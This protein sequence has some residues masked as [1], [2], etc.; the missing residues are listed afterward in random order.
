MADVRTSIAG[1]ASLAREAEITKVQDLLDRERAC[2]LVG[3][4]GSGKSALA[5]QIAEGNYDRRVWFA[6]TMLDHDT[7]RAFERAIDITHPFR[8]ILAASAQTCLIVFDSI[9]RYSARAHRLACRFMQTVLAEGSGINAHILVTGQFEPATRIL[10][11]F[12]EAGLPPA[13]HTAMPLALPSA[14]AIQDLVAPIAELQWASLRPELR[15]L[16]TNL[17]IL[18]WL[19]AAARSGKAINPASIISVSYL[20]D[21]LW[22]RWVEGETNQFAR[23]HLLMRLGSLEGDT[24]LASVPRMQLEHSEQAVLGGLIS[25]DLVRMRDQRVRFT[26]DMLGDWARLNVLLGEPSLSAPAVRARAKLPRWHRALRLYGQRLL[27]QADDGPEQ[28]RQAIEGLEDNTEE[29]A[30]I[31]DLFLEALF[32][33]SN[34]TELLERS[35]TALSAKGGRLLRLMLERFLFAA[36]LP[37]PRIDSLAA[38]G[39]RGQWEHLFRLPY[40]PYWRPML[41]VLHAHRDEIAKIAPHG[42]AKLCSLWLKSVPVQ[43]DDGRRMPWRREAAELS[44]VIG[45]EIQARNAAGDYFSDGHDRSAYEPC[46]LPHRICQTKLPSFAWSLRSDAISVPTSLRALNRSTNGGASD[47]ANISQP[48]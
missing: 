37:D 22:R 26:H 16:I 42:A 20:I 5:K 21:E 1:L 46:S 14:D 24:L 13:L 34:A 23:S 33:A 6:E 15:P 3:E 45:R 44:L 41:I 39:E 17:K 31:R 8:E 35:W 48:I 29:G 40:W 28:W 7:E 2:F 18:D 30:I 19:V 43:F 38:A 12:I 9:E 27:E 4:S 10:R 11:G 32:L 25:S 36:T 47:D